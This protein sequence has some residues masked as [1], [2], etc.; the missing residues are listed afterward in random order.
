MSGRGPGQRHTFRTNA[1]LDP[2]QQAAHDALA[3]HDLGVLVAP[4]RAGKTGACA[5]R[6]PRRLHTRPGRPQAWPTRTREFLGIN[7]GQRGG[8]RSK[9]TGVVDVAT[10]QPLARAEDVAD[11]AAGYGLVVVDECH[12]VPAAAFTSA[13]TQI[14]ARRWLGLTAP[15]YR[16]DQ[17][18]DLIG[19][20]LGP[21]RHILVPAPAGTLNTRS[22]EAP[23]PAWSRTR[24][25]PER[26]PRRTNRDL[27]SRTSA[28][29]G[30]GRSARARRGRRR[31]DRPRPGRS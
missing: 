24:C 20:Q 8:G 25:R 3:G 1:E 12:H 26:R 10:L 28:G 6:C 23:A 18:D 14:P 15:P 11:L 5:D 9:T 7:A 4:P 13:V 31:S 17:L 2:E 16:R 22:L 27:E 19:L 30:P 21:I 29:T